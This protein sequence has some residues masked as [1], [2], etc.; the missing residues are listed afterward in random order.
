MNCLY[1]FVLSHKL[2]LIID[3]AQDLIM[4]SHSL[5]I[6]KQVARQFRQ[7]RAIYKHRTNY[8]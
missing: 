3:K 4:T 6:G 7:T 1:R 8:V 5:H 2:S